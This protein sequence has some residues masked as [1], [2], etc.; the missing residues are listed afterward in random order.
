MN[1][2]LLRDVRFNLSSTKVAD[3]GIVKILRGVATLKHLSQL[4]LRV[5]NTKCK[6]ENMRGI[7]R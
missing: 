7:Q 6:Y 3:Q 2:D 4:S 1:H 5:F